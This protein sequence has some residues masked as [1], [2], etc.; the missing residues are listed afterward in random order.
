MFLIRRV[1]RL[2]NSLVRR[3]APKCTML[4]GLFKGPPFEGRLLVEAAEYCANACIPGGTRLSKAQTT[5]FTHGPD[6]KDSVVKAAD[7]S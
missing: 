1:I 3:R 2:G 6:R 7:V 4:A 5:F